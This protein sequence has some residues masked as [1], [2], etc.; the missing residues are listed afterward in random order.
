[1]LRPKKQTSNS[2]QSKQVIVKNKYVYARNNDKREAIDL[3]ECGEGYMRGYMGGVQGRG[4]MYLYY[5]LK[6]KKIL[7]EGEKRKRIGVG[8][9]RCSP[10]IWHLGGRGGRIRSSRTPSAAE[11]SLRSAWAM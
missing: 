8:V 5:N 1:M 9:W 11:A 4:E 2:V 10:V 6:N 3:K 7:N